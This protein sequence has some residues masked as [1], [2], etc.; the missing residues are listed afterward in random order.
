[1]RKTVI[2]S[3]LHLG[4][5]GVDG[6]GFWSVLSAGNGA[7]DEIRRIQ[8]AK[9]DAFVKAVED[10]SGGE[11][12]VLIG[13]GDILDLAMSHM[14]TCL[15]DLVALLKRLPM[16]SEFKFI[17]GNHDHTIWRMWSELRNL[18]YPML[19]GNEPFAGSFFEPTSPDGDGF[20]PLTKLLTAKLGRVF[21]VKA[22][23]P[24]LKMDS[25]EGPMVLHHGHLFGDLYTLVSDVLAPYLKGVSTLHAQTVVNAPTTE[26]IDW[27]IG[28]MGDR[29]GDEGGLA[30]TIFSD[31]QK[32]KS[33][34]VN[35]LLD[36]AVDVLLPDGIIKG[37]PDSWERWIAKKVAKK[38]VDGTLPHVNIIVSPDRHA[39]KSATRAGAAKW[40]A[41]VLQDKD[42]KVFVSGHTH[43]SD[44]FE[45]DVGGNKVRCLN[46][47]G[48]QVEPM[49]PNADTKMILVD[50][51]GIRLVEI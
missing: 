17:V 3:D 47:G 43:L 16:V 44:D 49:Y 33:S 20:E 37:I 29:M 21:P 24:I 36:Q 14:R 25:P 5:T 41:D 28:E 10:F 15:D 1:M 2:V 30:G 45:A 39:D 26:F 51:K 18:V 38:L 34:S 12:I 32:G 50:D 4:M 31:M 13:V 9:M 6:S 27:L 35:A 22:A 48:W 7:L 40:M 23:Y 46:P 8:S 42:V 19:F 11:P